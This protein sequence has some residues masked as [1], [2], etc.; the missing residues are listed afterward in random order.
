MKGLLLSRCVLAFIVLISVTQAVY[1][2]TP[3][4]Q[5]PQQRKVD[6]GVN[7]HPLNRG[8]Y[9]SMSLEQQLS[10]VKALGLTT[11]RVNVNPAYPDKFAR[12]SE[13]VNLAQREG[14]RILPVI[15]ILP[16]SY[17][18]EDVAYQD[19]KAAVS[20]LVTQFDARITTW[21]LGNEYDLYCVKKDADGSSPADYDTE[22]YAVVRGLLRGMLAALQQS[23]PSSRTIIQTSQHTGTSLDSGFLQRLLHDGISFDITGYHYYSKDGRIPSAKNGDSAL[24]I[25]HDKFHKPIWITEFDKS[26]SSPTIGPS[27]DPEAQGRALQTALSEIAADGDKYDVIGADIYEL[28]DQPELLD[29]PAVKPCQAQFGILGPRGGATDASRSVGK[30]M[31]SYY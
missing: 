16:K 9:D 3:A 6:F 27:S 14:V 11:Y 17:S 25:L 28:L 24:R 19:A 30:F 20:R 29:N 4:A 10:L 7:G 8:S 1:A 18:A 5:P 21:E 15:V 22:K 2:E 23:S 13:L 12:L 31:R 26:S